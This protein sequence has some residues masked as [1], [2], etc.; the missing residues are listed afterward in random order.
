[1]VL[2]ANSKKYQVSW[3]FCT[4]FFGFLQKISKFG[5]G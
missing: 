3:H 4:D 2:P 1:M 5:E